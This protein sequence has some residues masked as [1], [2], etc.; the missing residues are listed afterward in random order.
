MNGRRHLEQFFGDRIE[1]KRSGNG[2]DMFSE[3]CRAKSADGER[4]SDRDVVDHMIFLLMAAHDTTTSSLSSLIYHLAQDREWQHRLREEVVALDGDHLRY[5]DKD[6]LPQMDRAFKEAL[7]LHPPVPFI[8]RRAL[9]PVRL[10]GVDLP[11]GTSLSACSMVTHK[12][13]EHWTQPE[14]FDPER[15]SPERAEDR[16]HSHAYF[17][18]GGGAHT[19]IGMHFAYLQVKAILVQVLRRYRFSLAP[20]HQVT[21][22]PVPIPKPKEGLALQLEKIV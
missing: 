2:N 5:E 8:A 21:M 12:L 11:A 16:S 13:A 4:F 15:F 6:Q 18:F 9:R 17:P 20:G 22:I 14:R 3:F 7:R 1:D 10:G 19:C